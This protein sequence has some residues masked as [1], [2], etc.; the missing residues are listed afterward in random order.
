VFEFEFMLEFE[1]EFVFVTVRVA[2]PIRVCVRH[3][4]DLGTWANLLLS[5]LSSHKSCRDFPH[6]RV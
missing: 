5:V 2:V 3:C 4:R 1:F 6:C